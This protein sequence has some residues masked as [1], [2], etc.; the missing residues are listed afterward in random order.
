VILRAALYEFRAL[1]RHPDVLFW[2]IAWP[3]IWVLITAYVFV[4]PG[5]GGF[6]LDLAIV[7][8]GGSRQFATML[9]EIYENL[10]NASINVEIINASCEYPCKDLAERLV[11]EKDFEVVIV[12]PRNADEALIGRSIVDVKIFVKASSSSEAYMYQGTAM[13]GIGMLIGK[14]VQRNIASLFKEL[15]Y[16]KAMKV[17][18]S[19]SPVKPSIEEIRPSKGWDRASVLGLTVMGSVGYVAILNSMVTGAGIFAY[20][21]QG[22]VLRRLLSTP[23]RLRHLLVIDLATNFMI[24]AMGSAITVAVGIGIGARI[25]FDPVNASHWLAIAVIVVATLVAYCI[26]LLIALGVKD[27]RAASGISVMVSLI[28]IFTT[29]VWWP[30]KEMLRGFMR[31]LADW[32]P[33]SLAFDIAKQILVWN[34]SLD[35]LMPELTRFAITS[36]II[37]AIVVL[38]YGGGKRLEKVA[39]RVLS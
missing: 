21:T 19:I 7:D 33:L 22:E 9:A 34:R 3:I 26:G 17:L 15:G 5:G 16:E 6:S 38:A 20:R 35:V 13:Q 2:I 39:Y 36:L 30:P 25:L 10:S 14:F 37:V 8:T 32:S 29:G 27:P 24:V 28:L 11:K 23:L 31:T 18:A 4:P 12:L 1:L